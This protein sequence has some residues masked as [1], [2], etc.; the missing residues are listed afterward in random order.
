LLGLTASKALGTDGRL[1]LH[2]Y[3]RTG[4]AC[5][6]GAAGRGVRAALI[7]LLGGGRGGEP[8]VL[9]VPAPAAALPLA[10]APAPP[11]GADTVPTLDLATLTPER[12][13]LLA[14]RP[15]RVSFIPD[16]QADDVLGVW[17][18]EAAGSPGC[19]RIVAFDPSKGDGGLDV[20]APQV[21]APT[22]NPLTSGRFLDG[23]PVAE[24]TTVWA[25]TNGSAQTWGSASNPGRG[26]LLHVFSQRP[27]PPTKA[28][29]LPGEK[30]KKLVSCEG[31]GN[32]RP[33]KA[34]TGRAPNPGPGATS[35]STKPSALKSPAPTR[36]PPANAPS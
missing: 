23:F 19:L 3:A 21:G 1:P 24:L 35:T 27:R 34:S 28:A 36:A 8:L 10:D 12:V 4:R 14:G 7:G 33:L 18:V 22:A 31:V 13:A 32:A 2:W 26:N 16:S 6:R 5:H 15:V 11:V 17:A 9:R 20:V 30:A 25:D 29:S